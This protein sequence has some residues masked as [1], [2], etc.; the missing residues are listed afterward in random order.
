MAILRNQD[1]EQFSE[2]EDE[3]VRE[4]FRLLYDNTSI[5]QNQI[6]QLKDKIVSATSLANLQTELTTLFDS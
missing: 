4:S 1:Y 3:R 6:E 2:I 5:L